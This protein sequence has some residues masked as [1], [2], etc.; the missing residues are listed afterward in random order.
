MLVKEATRLKIKK[1]GI[2]MKEA[3]PD[4]RLSG[5]NLRIYQTTSSPQ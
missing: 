5:I 1:D 4:F 2:N 3:S